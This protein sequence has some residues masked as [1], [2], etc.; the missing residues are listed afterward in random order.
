MKVR[1]IGLVLAGAC[2]AGLSA[3]GEDAVFA[4]K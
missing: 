1:S 3:W 2:A 4:W